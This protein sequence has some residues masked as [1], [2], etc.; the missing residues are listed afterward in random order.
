MGESD[1][2]GRGKAGESDDDGRVKAGESDD[3]G[4]GRRVNLMITDR[5]RG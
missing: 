5:G 2:D 1:D 4:R 3:D